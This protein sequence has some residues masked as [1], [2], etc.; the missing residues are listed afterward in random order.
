MG[1]AWIKSCPWTN[2]GE[3]A[4]KDNCKV[5]YSVG[6]WKNGEYRLQEKYFG[7][8]QDN[9]FHGPGVYIFCNGT[10]KEG[11]WENGNLK[12]RQKT[13]FSEIKEAAALIYLF[14]WPCKLPY[15]QASLSPLKK[16][17]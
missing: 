1:F 4:F 3:T 8:F 9:K 12:H 13:K 6:Y 2:V 15:N 17:L 10:V 11:I 7:E 16:H 14:D 5:N